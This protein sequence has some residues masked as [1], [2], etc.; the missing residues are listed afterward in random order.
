MIFADSAKIIQKFSKNRSFLNLTFP[1]FAFGEIVVA[2]FSNDFNSCENYFSGRFWVLR[3]EK[4]Q[5]DFYFPN[6]SKESYTLADG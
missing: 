1:P 2:S 4:R 3:R 5:N 6:N